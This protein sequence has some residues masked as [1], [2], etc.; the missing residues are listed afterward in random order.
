VPASDDPSRQVRRKLD[1]GPLFPWPAVLQGSGLT[2]L[3]P[4]PAAAG[5]EKGEP[6]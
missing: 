3:I 2:R 4:P 5:R 6:L 1:P